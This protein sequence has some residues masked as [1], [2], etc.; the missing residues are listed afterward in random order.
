MKECTSCRHEPKWTRLA[1]NKWQE[2]L[3]GKT[4]WLLTKRRRGCCCWECR[5][6][7]CPDWKTKEAAK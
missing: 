3:C 6:V 4:G 7:V 5:I 2:G 1:G